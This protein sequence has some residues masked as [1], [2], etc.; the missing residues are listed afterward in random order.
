MKKLELD[1]ISG[2]RNSPDKIFDGLDWV[3]FDNK[4]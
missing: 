1:D 4:K 2:G 3:D